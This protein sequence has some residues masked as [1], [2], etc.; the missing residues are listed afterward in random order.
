MR[1][2]VKTCIIVFC[3]V[4]IYHTTC[5]AQDFDDCN[6]KC[7]CFVK[8]EKAPSFDLMQN[9]NFL[10][11]L[12]EKI[13]EAEGS[14]EFRILVDSSG[15]VCCT[16]IYNNTSAVKSA[17]LREMVNQMTYWKPALQNGYKV[18]CYTRLFINISNSK[19]T[20]TVGPE[21]K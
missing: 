3:G 12:E 4:V 13:K 10:K 11:E 7:P 5:L 17:D 19:L 8:A 20:A 6:I 9:G 21:I 18:A 15:K 16:N 1:Q 14:I 2:L